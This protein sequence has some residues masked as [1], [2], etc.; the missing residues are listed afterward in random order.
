MSDDVGLAAERAQLA[1]QRT[2]LALVTSAAI[3]ARF[4]VQH[5][6]PAVSIML[7]VATVLAAWVFLAA[8]RDYGRRGTNQAG[9]APAPA[10][11]LLALT[12][13]VALVAA[14]ELVAI[15]RS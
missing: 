9:R 12:A 10:L 4:S 13:T 14:A 2:A 1:R 6:G 15:T 5:V 3:A 11:H 7:G 8:R